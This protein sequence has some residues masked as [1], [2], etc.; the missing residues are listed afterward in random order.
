MAMAT[1]GAAGLPGRCWPL[2]APAG[3]LPGLAR[4]ADGGAV[5]DA[6]FAS[7]ASPSRS[8]STL[9]LPPPAPAGSLKGVGVPVK[10]LHE[11]TG[12]ICTVRRPEEGQR[13]SCGLAR[14]AAAA[15]SAPV[16]C[17]LLPCC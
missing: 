7:A 5:P 14:G 16:L 1:A 10:L 8:P 2:L 15:A 17:A 12:H 6:C 11:A 4:A 9:P 3:A 13:R